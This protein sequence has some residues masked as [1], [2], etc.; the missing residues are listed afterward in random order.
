MRKVERA[1]RGGGG[2]PGQ[3]RGEEDV[4]GAGEDGEGAAYA[5]HDRDQVR[6]AKVARPAGSASVG[7]RTGD[8]PD[9]RKVAVIVPVLVQRP[10]LLLRHIRLL[11]LLG[12]HFDLGGVQ[13]TN[14]TASRRHL[15]P[16]FNCTVT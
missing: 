14:R 9:E 15:C 13:N 1:Q 5:V 8:L 12:G 3:V 2:R 10:E 6:E 11:A 4:A 7:G 16:I